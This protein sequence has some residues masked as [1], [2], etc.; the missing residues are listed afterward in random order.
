MARGTSPVPCSRGSSTRRNPGGASF[1]PATRRTFPQ[2]IA[3]TKVKAPPV[4]DTSKIFRPL[5]V[6][7]CGTSIRAMASSQISVS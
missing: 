5:S 3:T 2:G 1:P 7:K 4:S 6:A